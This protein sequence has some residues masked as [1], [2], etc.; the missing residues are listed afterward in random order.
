MSL[1]GVEVWRRDDLNAA[2]HAG[3]AGKQMEPGKLDVDVWT[4]GLQP[5]KTKVVYVRV[6]RGQRTGAHAHTIANHYTC[7]VSGQA[8]LWV[9]GEMLELAPGDC[10]QVGS[11]LI[12]ELAAAR[13]ED[14][15]VFEASSPVLSS[16][17]EELEEFRS[18]RRLEIDARADEITA[19][20]E[21]A[22]QRGE[23]GI[24]DRVLGGRAT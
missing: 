5:E 12:H 10:F 2:E 3:S 8:L 16:D 18:V 20:F 21:L 11:G 1:N 6:G 13:G 9:E 7:I 22:F 24:D 19:A 17:V 23:G 14:C 4:V 15:W